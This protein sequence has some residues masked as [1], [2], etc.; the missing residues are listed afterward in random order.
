MELLLMRY[1]NTIK[2]FLS[3]VILV[4]MPGLFS[5]SAKVGYGLASTEVVTAMVHSEPVSPA[6]TAQQ[7]LGS[8]EATAVGAQQDT[9]PEDVIQSNEQRKFDYYFYAALNA[10]ALGKYDEA[11]D[12]LLHCHALDSTNANVLVELG[13]F[14]NVLQEKN[15]A[16]DF[17]RKAVQYDETN[18]YYNMVLAGLSKELGLKQEVVD[19]YEPML[20]LYPDKQELHFEMANAYADNGELEKA[21]A[22]LNELEKRTG[23]TEVLTLNKFR[24]YSMMDK[25]EEAYGEIQQ[26][27]DKNPTD[28]KYLVLMAELFMEDNRNDDAIRYLEQAREIDPDF[29]PLTIALVNYFE[30]TNNR[31]EA[32]AV[33]TKAITS[34]SMELDAKL[35]LLTR[36]LAIL[37][38]TEQELTQA[39]PLFESLF[40]QHPNASRLNLIYGSVLM[41]QE[42]PEGAM[43]Q[44]EIFTRE[45]PEDPAGYDQMLR[46]V[47][48]NE[49]FDKVVE[50]TTEALKHL[51]GEPQFY[52]YLGGAYYQ[53]QKYE[54][55]LRIFEEG[56]EKAN[57]PNSIVESNFHGQIGDLHHHLGDTVTAFESYEQA[58]KLDPQ[59]L[60]VLNNYSYFL[61]LQKRELD[62]AEQMSGITVKLEPT[63]PTFLDTY[64]WVLFEQGAYVMAKIYL[65][66]AIEYSKEEPSA[67]L[68]EHYGDVLYKTGDTEGAAREWLKAKE[69]GGDSEALDK[70]IKTG[71]L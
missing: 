44:F 66:K 11:L 26:I 18:Y 3:L 37:Q 8:P 29:P 35:Q 24:L 23:I 27:I 38:Q 13:T 43:E 2:R 67:V 50:I 5:V 46:I 36:Y 19:I 56:L 49:E 60:H 42:N 28:P 22:S 45:N 53:Q 63:N 21:V 64:G 55:A 52:F 47:V 39:N 31:V 54:E 34:P 15:R 4:V 41:L 58:L 9:P 71:E 68:H 25:K 48:P 62:K 1:V 12:L 6:A 40:E 70:K 14:Y 69:L 20:A 61:S 57:F 65:E 7:T 33:L 32:Q 10:K 16:L 17:F 51:P 30:R 59:N